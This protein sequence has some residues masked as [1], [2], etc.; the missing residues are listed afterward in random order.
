MQATAKGEIIMYSNSN[1]TR[2][3]AENHVQGNREKTLRLVQTAVLSA[4]LI[5]MA[6]TPIGYL[7]AG[8]V[9]ITFMMI[10][11]VIG[12]IVNGPAH[13]AFL[14]GIFGATSFAQCFGLDWFGT[15]LFSINPF[16]TF[17]MTM[18]PR[19]IMGLAVAY[20]YRLAAS[21]DKEGIW[22]YAVAGLSGAV[23]NTVLFVGALIMFFGKTEFIGQF[24]ETAIAVIGA[25]V[26]VNAAIEAAVSTVVGG[27]IAKTIKRVFAR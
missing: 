17:I 3:Y 5:L 24:G 21:K 16:Y 25:L 14:G 8:P 23:V 6:F 7:K 12:A 18:I 26:T 11:V 15:T 19:I 22:S 10:P 20:I 27:A 9:S 4:I 1:G 2:T 13:G